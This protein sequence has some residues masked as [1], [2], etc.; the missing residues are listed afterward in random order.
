MPSKTFPVVVIGASAG[1]VEA[2]RQLMA[3][4][5]GSGS[6]ADDYFAQADDVVAKA[7]PLRHLVMGTSLF[8]HA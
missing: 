8:G 6:L 4:E 7:E 1:G 3:K 2:L 5:A